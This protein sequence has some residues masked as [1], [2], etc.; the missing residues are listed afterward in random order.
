[1]G[2]GEDGGAGE[3]EGGGDG[4]VCGVG[5]QMEDAMV[6]GVAGGR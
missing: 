3:G 6:E 2:G 1:M 4:G 5:L